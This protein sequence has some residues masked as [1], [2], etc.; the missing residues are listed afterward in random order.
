MMKSHNIN[1]ICNR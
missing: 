1:I